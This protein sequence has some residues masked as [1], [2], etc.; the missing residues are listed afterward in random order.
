MSFPI[1]VKYE[2]TEGLNNTR[3]VYNNGDT[4]DM[5][6][7]LT[8]TDVTDLET[9][10]GN[11]SELTTTEKTNLVGAINEVDGDVTDLKADLSEVNT[12]LGIV[13]STNKFNPATAV[14]GYSIGTSGNPIASKTGFTSDFIPCNGGDTFY[15][16][17]A[18]IS[19]SVH[20][21]YGITSA[22]VSHFAQYDADKNFISGTRQTWANSVVLDENCRYIRFSNP[23]SHLQDEIRI[24]SVTF[25]GY[26]SDWHYI[27]EYFTPYIY[28]T[29]DRF[30]EHVSEANEFRNEVATLVYPAN[31]LN[32]NNVLDNTVVSPSGDTA[33][34]TCFT[35]NY[36]IPAVY[37]DVISFAGINNGVFY[38]KAAKMVNIGMYDADHNLLGTSG[39]YVQDFTIN[40]ANCAYIRVSV[41]NAAKNYL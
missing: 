9:K 23:L 4:L 8:D 28:L 22:N 41:G 12:A 36:F 2:S 13:E 24:I 17:S 26:P 34:D 39:F 35:T 16:T 6:P 27:T 32:L 37:G 15:Y 31:M 10:I 5:I 7:N 30:D 21:F 38:H 3:V 29:A 20:A 25:N 1:P 40:Q 14:E 11:L 33:N 18:R 19:D